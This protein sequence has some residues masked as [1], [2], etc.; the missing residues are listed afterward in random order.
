MN[1]QDLIGWTG[2]ITVICRDL[3]GNETERVTF[4]NLITNK[5]KELLAKS[6]ADSSLDTEIKY[7]AIGDN[8]TAPAV[9]DIALGNERF[10]KAVTKQ[11][12]Q[13]SNAMLT[14]VY[15]A[16]YEANF[17]IQE[18]GWFAGSSATATAGSGALVARVLYARTKTSTESIQF[19]RTDTIT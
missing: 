18:I 8:A 3:D 14:T 9:G 6:L 7:I 5:G 19:D 13:G 1:L 10:R 2:V 15:I 12:Y 4:Q 17:A 16:P 11:E